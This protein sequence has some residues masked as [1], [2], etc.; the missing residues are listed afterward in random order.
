MEEG[1]AGGRQEG[2]APPPHSAALSSRGLG[3]GLCRA[4]GGRCRAGRMSQS[5]EGGW[6][7]PLADG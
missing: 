2:W 4:R 1:E 7:L 5:G 3:S 6:G